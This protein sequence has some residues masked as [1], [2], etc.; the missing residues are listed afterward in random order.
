MEDQRGVLY[1]TTTHQHKPCRARYSAA[2]MI[3][4]NWC[5]SPKSSRYCKRWCCCFQ[6]AAGTLHSSQSFPSGE[7]PNEMLGLRVGVRRRY[8]KAIC[9][10]RQSEIQMHCANQYL[11]LNTPPSPSQAQ[12][13]VVFYCSPFS[14]KAQRC[15]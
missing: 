12:A 5:L 15:Q 13:A 10:L 14:L 6:R 11:K 2:E 8:S 7:S 3:I 4:Q 1:I 9:A